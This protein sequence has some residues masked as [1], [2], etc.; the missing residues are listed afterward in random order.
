[1]RY[2]EFRDRVAVITGGA[3]GI[4]AATARLLAAEGAKVA[5]AD[6]DAGGLARM[7]AEFRAAAHPFLGLR[8]DVA[9]ERQ[10]AAMVERTR[11]ELGEI[12]LLVNDAGI[13]PKHRGRKLTVWEM[14]IE[15]SQH[16][17]G[18]A[19]VQ[20]GRHAT[21]RLA[22]GQTHSGYGAPEPFASLTCLQAM[23]QGGATVRIVRPLISEMLPLCAATRGFELLRPSD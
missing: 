15:E 10:I 20:G 4:G 1:M 17:P 9:D 14:P 2:P 7:E 5:V 13:S 22:G 12:D 3:S 8:V 18:K 19:H 6:I 23:E 16:R 11:G 21:V